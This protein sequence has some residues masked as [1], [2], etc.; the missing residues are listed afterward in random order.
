MRI[1]RLLVPA[2][3]AALAFAAP[4]RAEL[5]IR[6]DKSLQQM[7]VD[8]DG[9]T[10][11]TW[12]VSS[13]RSGYDTPSGEYKPFRMEKDHFSREWDDAP[14]PFSIFFTMEGHAIHG[15]YDTKNLGKPVSHGCVR[16]S[17]ANA[18]TLWGLVKREK[19]A[20]TRVVLKGEAPGA[21]ELV[22]RRAPARDRDSNRDLERQFYSA[23]RDDDVRIYRDEDDDV[24]VA[25]RR[26][27][28]V[29]R[30]NGWREYRDGERSYYTRERPYVER[31]YYGSPSPFPF[32]FR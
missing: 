5:I 30:N 32:P 16:L 4:A 25:P 8:V 20:N 22:A 21:D 28:R 31:R 7:T 19:M 26:Q 23:D 10:L 13:G 29:T 14:M 15:T 18:E 2:V 3:L 17:R 9:A 6:V 12:P 1:S 11:F 24:V 27:R